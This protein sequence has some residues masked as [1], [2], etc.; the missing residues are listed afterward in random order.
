MRTTTYFELVLICFLLVG[1]GLSIRSLF[2]IHV[3]INEVVEGNQT[4]IFENRVLIFDT[5]RFKEI[6]ITTILSVI[7]GASASILAIVF[8]ISNLIISNISD[9][10]TPLILKSYEQDAPTRRTFYSFVGATFF[11]LVSLFIYE[12][13]PLV[14]S[15]VLLLSS[16]FGFAISLVLLIDYFFYMFRIVNPL[17]FALIL[18]NK[19]VKQVQNQD[20]R[21]VQNSIMSLGDVAVKGFERKELQICS[22]YIKVLYNIFK[23]YLDLK[24]REPKRYTLITSLDRSENR[25]C[26]LLYVLDQYFR[27]FK[28]SINEK[29]ETI[30]KEIVSN[31]FYILYE[32]LLGKENDDLIR[33]IMETRYVIG[34][35]Y[36]PFYELAVESKDTSRFHLIQDLVSILQILMYRGEEMKIEDD[37]LEEFIGSHLFR[38]NQLIID[39]DD[40]ELFRREINNFSLMLLKVSPD[41]LQSDFTT[42]LQMHL[43]FLYRDR[44]FMEEFNRKRKHLEYLV[45]HESA[46]NFRTARTLDEELKKYESF[47]IAH[48]TKLRNEEYV[49]SLLPE[50]IDPE[51][52]KEII[53]TSNVSTQDIPSRIQEVKNC[54]YELYVASQICRMFFL[55]GAYL[56]FKEKQHAIDSI[57]YIKELWSHTRPDDARFIGLNRPPITFNPLWLTY[58]L[59]YG[60]EG[61]NSWLGL[62]MFRDFHS[63]TDYA[64][65]YYLLAIVDTKENFRMPSATEL[66]ELRKNNLLTELGHWYQVSNDFSSSIQSLLNCCDSLIENANY[67]DR[68]LSTKSKDE[69]G[70]LLIIG[71][72]GKLKSTKGWIESKAKEVEETKQRVINLLPLDDKRIEDCKSQILNSYIK[73]SQI[74]E[75]AQ[76]FEFNKVR[77]KDLHFVRIDQSPSLRTIPKDCLTEPSSVNCSAIWS[78]LG[79]GVAYGEMNHFIRKILKHK[80]IEKIDT[81][82]TSIEAL[83]N[84]IIDVTNNLKQEGFN[85]ATICIPLKYLTNLELRQ[86]VTYEEKGS[87]LKIDDETRLRIIYSTKFVQFEDFIVLDKSASICTYKPNKDPAKRLVVNVKELEKDQSSVD[88]LVAT[89]INL[90]TENPK[91]LKILKC[92]IKTKKKKQS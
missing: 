23:E 65:K 17:R 86:Y 82:K 30:T 27:I 91:A 88:V 62:R 78:R 79:E 11:S 40:F 67:F 3:V 14:I 75:I 80:E 71:A 4:I 39:N 38:V 83:Y 43:H 1:I 6:P 41:E 10:Y 8:A 60:G 74:S 31:L 13:V 25:N 63:V 89:T 22:E 66:D 73:T 44:D 87:L 32:T 42:G 51:H 26:V 69:K 57:A 49:K 72:E 61:N 68:L 76:I 56:L 7:V 92:K 36:Y 33:Q 28:Y 5:E 46:K 18:K 77:D 45:K 52:I 58:L 12:L 15:F 90:K 19:T 2:E 54:A 9:R 37:Y 53:D 59:L 85:P 21:E 55:I 81:D 48:F 70:N 16:I 84:K 64:D 47:L 35:K 50:T 29:E 34:A 24:K 20:E